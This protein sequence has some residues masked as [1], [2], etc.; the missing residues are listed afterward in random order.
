MK[1]A[2]DKKQELEDQLNVAHTECKR[3]TS[4]LEKAG[5]GAQSKID[6]LSSKLSILKVL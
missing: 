3:L 6:H 1:A 4:D 2:I 5:Q